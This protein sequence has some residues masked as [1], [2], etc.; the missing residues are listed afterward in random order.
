[1]QL[2][3]FEITTDVGHDDVGMEWKAQV[4]FHGI[5]EGTFASFGLGE[6]VVGH[7]TMA[8]GTF[9][10][11]IGE[12]MRPYIQLYTGDDEI[13]AADAFWDALERAARND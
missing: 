9:E 5:K 6:E 4:N 8:D 7:L 12:P 3:D 2:R 11:G 1:M 13:K 10:V